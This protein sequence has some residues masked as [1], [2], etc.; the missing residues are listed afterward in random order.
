MKREIADATQLDA[1][2]NKNIEQLNLK[3]S[4]FLNSFM[5]FHAILTPERC[6]ELVGKNGKTPR[7]YR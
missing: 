6:S 4:K 2:H 3:L 5:E 7:T 1:L